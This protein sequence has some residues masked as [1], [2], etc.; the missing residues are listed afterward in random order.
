MFSD[1]VGSTPLWE[2]N[3]EATQA[4]VDQHHALLRQAV[5]TNGGLVL[6]DIGDAFQ[7]AFRLTYDGLRAALEA[8]RLLLDAQRGPTAPLKEKNGLA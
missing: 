7:S 6:Q 8:Q 2:K 3:P 4:A 1:I 5:E